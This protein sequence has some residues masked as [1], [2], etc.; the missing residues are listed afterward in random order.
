MLIPPNYF[1]SWGEGG[2]EDRAR[3]R[4]AVV[5]ATASS[6]SGMVLDDVALAGR[7]CVN[8]NASGGV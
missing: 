6:V 8:I 5:T 4:L 1:L 7:A 2:E 3:L